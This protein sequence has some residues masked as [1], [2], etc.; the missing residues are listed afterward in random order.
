[1]LLAAANVINIGADIGAL[2]AAAALIIHVPVAVLMV[3]FTAVILA[4]EM[5]VS[6]RRY[7]RVLK[8]L[9]VSLLAYPITALLVPQP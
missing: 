9:A 7:A 5:R 3:G 1:V 2:G 4:L 8:W 6:Y